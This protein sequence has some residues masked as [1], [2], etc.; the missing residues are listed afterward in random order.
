MEVLNNLIA[1]FGIAVTPIHLW[2]CFIG[3]FA[4][5]FIGVLPGIGPLTAT[6]LL[7]PFTIHLDP[8]SAIIMLAGIYYGSEYGG[9]VSSILLNLPGTVGNAVTCI[10]GHQMAKQGR[11]GLALFITTIAS[12]IGGFFGIIAIIAFSNII[13]NMGL[14]LGPAEYFSLMLLGLISASTLATKSMLK[15]FAMVLFGLL[16]STIGTDAV[17]GIPR[18]YFNTSVLIDGISLAI[19]VVGFFGIAELIN[20]MSIKNDPIHNNRIT[21]RAM[22]PKKIDLK[23]STFPMIRGSLVGTFFGALPGTGAAIAAFVS[24]S[25][26]K[27]VHKNSD[28]F[29]KGAIEGVVSPEAANNA[30]AQ[31]AFIPTL[32]LGI[33]GSATMA[34]ILGAL[35]I[36]GVKPGP[37]F[38]VE[39]PILFWGL[40]ASFFIGNIILVILN[41]PLIS[42]WVS[43]LKIPKKILFPV[44]ITLM[45]IG[46]Y[47][48]NKNVFDI[49]MLGIFGLVG[50]ILMRCDYE[51]APMLLGFV[52]GP[53]MEENLRRAL[54]ISRGDLTS[55]IDRPISMSILLICISLIIY[56]IFNYI[57]KEFNK[58]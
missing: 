43:I 46:I 57:K 24:Y 23:K 26:E 37:M 5:T 19:I 11:A 32:T 45:L 7:L 28:V 15:G 17:S 55:F 49:Y 29:G 44:I 20:N 4:G 2:Y 35:M 40:I 50:Y 8:L 13:A 54:V 16:L 41:I 12:L 51:F 47:S 34:I 3:V 9:S 48:I 31:S 58:N 10:D 56:S 33:P 14:T 18:F 6:T 27:K 22:I 39:Q 1:G 38:I 21:F 53:L 25:L 36:H 52:L 30:A 42:L